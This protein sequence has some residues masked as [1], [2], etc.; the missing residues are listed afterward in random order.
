MNFI[1]FDLILE[2]INFSGI[3]RIPGKSE[4]ICINTSFFFCSQ[5]F[6]RQIIFLQAIGSLF[7]FEKFSPKG[8]FRCRTSADGTFVN[9]LRGVVDFGKERLERHFTIQNLIRRNF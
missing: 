8:I 2:K 5:R 9:I 7:F 1:I 6:G 4:K 3:W